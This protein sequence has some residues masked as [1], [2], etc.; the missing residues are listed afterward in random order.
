MA[1]TEPVPAR[2]RLGV[3]TA[4]MQHMREGHC[5]DEINDERLFGRQTNRLVGSAQLVVEEV[6]GG[7]G[8]SFMLALFMQI[9][10]TTGVG[11]DSLVLIQIERW[12]NRLLIEAGAIDGIEG[13]P[14]SKKTS[15]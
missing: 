12:L 7:D 11:D 9:A 4:L 2:D 3:F 14:D 15:H 10:L 13:P 5:C 1:D 8:N 6:F